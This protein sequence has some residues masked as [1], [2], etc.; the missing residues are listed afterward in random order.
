M[1]IDTTR[2]HTTDPTLDYYSY[3]KTAGDKI[4]FTYKHHFRD[5]PEIADDEGIKI[6]I[7]EVPEQSASFLFN[8]SIELR[9]AKSLIHFSCFCAPGSPVLI[10]QGF[11]EGI[12]V[13]A[14]AWK[15]TANLQMPWNSQ[16]TV[17]IDVIFIL[18]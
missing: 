13:S 6:I 16:E 15:I 7:F 11:I 9:A 17:S 8:D 1:N 18:Q 2:I 5:C 4:V 14:N 10:K 3:T 12:K